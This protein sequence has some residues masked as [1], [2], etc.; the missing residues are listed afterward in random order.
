MS[1]DIR[2][3]LEPVIDWYQSDEVPGRNTVDIVRDVVADLVEDREAILNVQRIAQDAQRRLQEGHSIDALATMNAV[4]SALK[5]TALN[6]P[7]MLTGSTGPT[8]LWDLE[9]R[10][11]AIECHIGLNGCRALRLNLAEAVKPR[12]YSLK[13]GVT[14]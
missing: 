13:K 10:L 11:E 8:T 9:Q 2:E 14:R 4:L 1:L 12:K 3:A 5:G 6:G 7:A